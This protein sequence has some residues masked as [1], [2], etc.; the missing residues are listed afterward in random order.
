MRNALP[1]QYNDGGRKAAGFKGEAGDCLARAIAIAADVPYRDAY[2]LINEEA[3][4][5]RTQRGRTGRLAAT[6]RGSSARTGVYKGTAKRVL[7]SLG[8][9]FV[10]TMGIGTGCTVHLAQGELPMGRIIASVSKHFVA[11][12]DGVLLDT[13]DPSRDGTRCVYGYWTQ[14]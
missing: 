1:W 12:V 10:A 11:V 4:G 3:Q 6:R 7:Q 8:W 9:R 13:D 5:E 2:T 14:A